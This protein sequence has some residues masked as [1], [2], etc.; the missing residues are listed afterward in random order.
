MSAELSEAIAAMIVESGRA[1]RAD[2]ERR[3]AAKRA[4]REQKKRRRDAG[5]VARHAA[6]LARIRQAAG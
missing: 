1:S 4:E 6:K 3:Q 2:W 5:L